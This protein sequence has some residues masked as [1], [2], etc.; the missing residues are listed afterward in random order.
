M[1]R[2]SREFS[3]NFDLVTQTWVL[4]GEHTAKEID[5]LRQSLRVEL[6]AGPGLPHPRINGVLVQGWRPR[7]QADRVA[8]YELAFADWAKTIRRERATS[9]R[10][11]AEVRAENESNKNRK[12]K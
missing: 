2:V 8:A 10:I 9:E 1:A 11:A 4:R 5:Q 6:S 3:E 12:A 7:D